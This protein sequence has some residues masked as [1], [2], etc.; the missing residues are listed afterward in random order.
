MNEYTVLLRVRFSSASTFVQGIDWSFQKKF[1]DGN[2]GG[3]A[4]CNTDGSSVR[5]YTG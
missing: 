1:L 3:G 2:F 4:K 5:L